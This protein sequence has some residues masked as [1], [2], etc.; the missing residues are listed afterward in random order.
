MA[1]RCLSLTSIVPASMLLPIV[2]FAADLKF[3]GTLE[4]L[5]RESVSIRLPDRIAVDARLPNTSSLSSAAIAAKYRLGDHV[6]IACREINPILEEAV[7]RLLFIELTKI[8]FVRTASPEELVRAFRLPTW[9]EPLNLLLPPD[10]RVPTTAVKMN[11]PPVL[12]D[13]QIEAHATLERA[14]EVNL[15]YIAH[16]PNFV[17]D[18]TGKRYTSEARFPDW[19]YLDRI[20][21]EITVKGNR[22]DRQKVRRDGKPWKQPY[23][24]LPGFKWSGGFG[25]ELRPI[26]DLRCP[27]AIE[28]SGTAV[29]RGKRVLEY[30]FESP[31]D[32]CFG[33]FTNEYARY[34]PARKGRIFVEDFV[35]D[36]GGNVLQLEEEAT[37]FPEQFEFS[38]RVETVSWD[39]VKIGD[40]PHLLPVAANFV[41]EYFSG[42][43]VRV[44]VEYKNHRHFESSTSISFQ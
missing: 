2:A 31:A 3:S 7:G 20:E 38:H 15:N 42:S 10:V 1:L 29:M 17:A 34:N 36:R 30:R 21:T 24:F 35:G 41:V 4:L 8:R 40:A 39:Y 44:D 37:D 18:E 6:E 43:R 5:G 19:R 26:F 25:T 28:Y 33:P 27:T 22:S 16:L 11:D 23:Q 14:R 12:T 13:A 32:G 9:R